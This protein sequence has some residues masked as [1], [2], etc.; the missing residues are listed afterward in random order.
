[1]GE[2]IISTRMTV[3]A[4]IGS[5]PGEWR[6]FEG[7]GERRRRAARPARVTV[8]ARRAAPRTA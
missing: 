6:T 7:Q 3:D 5:N 1:M 4:V 2:L 8:S